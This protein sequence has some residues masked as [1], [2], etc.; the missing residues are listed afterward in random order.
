MGHGARA[1]QAGVVAVFWPITLWALGSVLFWV[2]DH[3]LRLLL[4]ATAFGWLGMACCAA[5]AVLA[6]AARRHVRVQVLLDGDRERARNQAA[7]AYLAAHGVQVSWA[8]PR[9]T[10]THE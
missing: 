1:W 7:Y 8:D 4:V 5:A 3:M 9:F 6:A 2:A 10:A